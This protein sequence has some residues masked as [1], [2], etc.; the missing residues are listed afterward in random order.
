MEDSLR[1]GAVLAAL[2]FFFGCS[3]SD[4]PTNVGSQDSSLGELADAGKDESCATGLTGTYDDDIIVPVGTSCLLQGATVFGNVKALEGAELYVI[5]SR[6]TGNVEGDE[7]RI[8]QVQ[9]G[10]VEGNIQIKD[11]TSPGAMG[12]MVVGTTVTEGDVQIEKM[13]TGEILVDGVAILEGNLQVT[14]N[15]V[16]LRLH[17]LN[18]PVAAG[19]LQVFKNQG[20]GDKRV[21]QNT[22]SQDLQC[23]ENAL[24]FTGGPNTA[25]ETEG[26]C[27]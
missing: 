11:G 10:T 15:H 23:K 9:G 22:V 6:V 2:T 16:G 14:E 20:D 19:N 27:F 7:A 17:L 8:V 18:N 13:R 5:D 3:G 26:Q 12:A 4:S 21:Q 24:P 25:G 1:I